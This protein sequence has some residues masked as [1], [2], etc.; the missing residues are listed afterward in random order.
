MWAHSETNRRSD[1]KRRVGCPGGTSAEA[2]PAG[3]P[4]IGISRRVVDVRRRI[5]DVRDVR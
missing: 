4:L 1:A 5:A 3:L 2:Q